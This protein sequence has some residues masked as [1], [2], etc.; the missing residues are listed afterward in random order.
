M[1]NDMI[2]AFIKRPKITDIDTMENNNSVFI[3]S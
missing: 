3:G 1:S 2:F